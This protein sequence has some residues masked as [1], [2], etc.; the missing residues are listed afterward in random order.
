YFSKVVKADKTWVTAGYASFIIMFTV[1]RLIGDKIVAKLGTLPVIC[2]SGLLMVVG[3]VI[4]I[5]VPHVW[6]ASFGFLLV[7]LGGS[8]VVPM[9]YSL[10]G[11]TT[12]M[13]PAYS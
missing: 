10:A 4:A 9:V 3:F 5:V 11:Q 7:G 13:L 8:I 2:Y 12:S 1:G 6:G